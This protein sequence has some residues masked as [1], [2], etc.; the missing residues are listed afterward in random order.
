MSK[1][2]IGV[3]LISVGWMGNLHTRAY[4]AL[5]HTYPELGVDAQLIIAADTAPDRANMRKM[6][7]A[8]AKVQLIIMMS[9]SIQK[10]M[11]SQYVR[12]IS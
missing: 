6:Y 9:L 11:W 3:G 12:Q 7:L 4:Q 2:K 10:L 5:N 8:I 1:K